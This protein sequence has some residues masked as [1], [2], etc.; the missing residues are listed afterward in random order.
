M[1]EQPLRLGRLKPGG[2]LAVLIWHLSAQ[3]T[4]GQLYQHLAAALPDLWH[5]GPSTTAVLRDFTA[6]YRG[7]KLDVE[8]FLGARSDLPPGALEGTPLK[9]ITFTTAQQILTEP[10][11]W[12][13]DIVR[14]A[15]DRLAHRIAQQPPVDEIAAAHSWFV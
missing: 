14:T 2:R 6:R 11:P 1:L 13:T 9:Q 12:P 7:A 4:R 3:Q 10:G 5:S 8:Q 15:A